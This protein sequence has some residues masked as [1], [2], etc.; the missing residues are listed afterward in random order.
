M[1]IKK[2]DVQEIVEDI[3]NPVSF[4]GEQEHDTTLWLQRE[5]QKLMMREAI[6]RAEEERLS[7]LNKRSSNKRNS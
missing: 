7:N 5:Y 1:M 2:M 6:V 4:D 3:M